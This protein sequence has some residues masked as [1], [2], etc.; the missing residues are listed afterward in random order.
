MG[1]TDNNMK[2]IESQLRQ[3]Q[4][5]EQQLKQ[6][7]GMIEAVAKQKMTKEAISRYGNLKMAHP[8]TAVKAIAFIAQA[9]AAGQISEKLGDEDFKHILKEIQQGKKEFKL[10]R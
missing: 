3:Q 5:V 9:A 10:K 4:A 7:I 6:Q 8:E 2:E 1:D